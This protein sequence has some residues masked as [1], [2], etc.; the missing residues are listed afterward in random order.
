MRWICQ[1]LVARPM[2]FACARQAAMGR[3]HSNSIYSLPWCPAYWYCIVYLKRPYTA[4]TYAC[5]CGWMHWQLPHSQQHSPLTAET[6]VLANDLKKEDFKVVSLHPG[7]VATDMGANASSLMSEM[8]PG[9]QLIMC[10][11][12]LLYCTTNLCCH[13]KSLWTHKQLG[14]WVHWCCTINSVRLHHQSIH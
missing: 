10:H 3:L 8:R 14:L 7:F 11:G 9:E 6:T 2:P 5:T 4:C 13:D 1:N 12:N